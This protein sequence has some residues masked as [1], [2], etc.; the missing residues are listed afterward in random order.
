MSFIIVYLSPPEIDSSQI[1]QKGKSCSPLKLKV[2]DHSHFFLRDRNSQHFNEDLVAVND[3]AFG[4]VL[5]FKAI[6]YTGASHY[7]ISAK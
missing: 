4:F 5:F 6:D 3:S 2:D 7:V 1:E